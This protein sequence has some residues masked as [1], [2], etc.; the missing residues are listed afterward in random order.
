[1]PEPEGG[2]ARGTKLWRLSDDGTLAERDDF[3]AA[4]EPLEIRVEGQS[5]AVVMRTPGDD[6]ALTAGFLLTEGL[7]KSRA[8]LFDITRCLDVPEEA[9]GNVVEVA[10]MNPQACEL[11]SLTRHVFSSSSCGICGKATIAAIRQQFAVVDDDLRVSTN[12]ILS[13]PDRLAAAQRT[14]QR[15]GALHACALFNTLGEPLDVREDVGRHNAL[16][17]LVGHALLNDCLPLR[18]RILLLSGRTSFEMMQK[19]LAAGISVVAAISAP[20]SLAVEFAQ[21]SNQTLIGFLR[22]ET[23]NVYAGPQRLG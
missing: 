23:M 1:M 2:S 19:A 12:V 17:K 7:I 10:L 16:D 18:G 13:L 9:R 21:E 15:T 3:L 4:E 5:V 20:T 6:R 11:S 14:F 8:D 22:G